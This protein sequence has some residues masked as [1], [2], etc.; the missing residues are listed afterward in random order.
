MTKIL[1]LL[2]T[3]AFLLIGCGKKLEDSD[4]NGDSGSINNATTSES[5][6]DIEFLSTAIESN[7]T[8]LVRQA[9]S[10][11]SQL[12]FKFNDGETP[13]TKAIKSSKSEIIVE[14]INKAD[15]CNLENKYLEIPV[16][17]IIESKRLDRFE[18]R[19]LTKKLFRQSLDINKRGINGTTP[20]QVAIRSKEEGIAML[21]TK[22]GVNL[23]ERYNG[24]EM[25]E[26]AKT[27][28]LTRLASLL[29]EIIQSPDSKLE[30]L[31]SAIAKNQRN[32]LEYLVNKNSNSAQLINENNLLIDVLNI[33]NPQERTNILNYLLRVSGVDANGSG[34]HETPLQYAARQF[35]SSHQRSL[36]YLL[37]SGAD[38]YLRDNRG[39]NAL[40][41]AARNLNLENVKFLYKRIL[42]KSRDTF[43][44]PN[45]VA[46]KA[47]STAC[48]KTPSK[49]VAENILWNGKY[50]RY[51]ILR[52]MRC[53][54]Y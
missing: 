37:R 18:K 11:L 29:E 10:S 26:L 38:L 21:L 2:A 35:H 33:S 50:K 7:D 40:D 52:S 24:V 48:E 47:I 49:K 12:N 46:G 43:N 3:S 4:K 44:D 5:A 25:L 41:L 30:T 16:N 13:L 31:K 39:N 1:F 51:Q 54:N 27:Y 17:L 22:K 28:E 9:L 15:I 20:I 36:S 32:L 45:S 19:D 14:I 23:S 34:N 42:S 53:P 6:K 8:L